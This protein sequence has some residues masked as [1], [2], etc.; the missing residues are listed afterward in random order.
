[1]AAR[2]RHL[3]IAEGSAFYDDEFATAGA[4]IRTKA[5][6]LLA[7][8]GL[9]DGFTCTLLSTA[10]YGMHKDTAKVSQHYLAEVGIDAE[11]V[12]PDWST[13]VSSAI[14]ASTTSR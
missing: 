9:P 1:M 2:S 3:P 4:T 6:A 7:E 13:R 12:L 14:A 8:A 11:L 5:K 10:Q